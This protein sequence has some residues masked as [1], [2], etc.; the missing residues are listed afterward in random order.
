MEA[1]IGAARNRS[2]YRSPARVLVDWFRKSRD[3]WKQKF[4]KRKA[5]LKR[6]KNRAYDLERSREHWKTQATTHQQQVEALQAEVERLKAQVAEYEDGSAI[7]KQP[8]CRR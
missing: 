7:K 6:F 3:G 2:S 4:M 1:T 8:A 5:D